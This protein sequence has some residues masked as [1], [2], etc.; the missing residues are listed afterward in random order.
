MFDP[1]KTADTQRWFDENLSAVPLMAV[2]RGLDPATT[3]RLAKVAWDIGFDHV[4]VPIESK[5]AIPSLEAAIRA[6]VELGKVVGAGTILNVEQVDIAIEIG[7]AYL[8]SPGLDAELVTTATAR[9]V[10]FLPGVSSPSEILAARKLGLRWLKAFPG[11]LLGSGW[12][13]AM[14]GPFPEIR[15]VATGGMSGRNASEYLAAGCSVVGV[16]SALDDPEQFEALRELVG[17]H[18]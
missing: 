13:T 12:I 16:G 2:L 8:V 15:F 3:V 14:H 17:Q 11:S 1:Q 7:A 9:D 4:E 10:P 18:V 5:A 6:G